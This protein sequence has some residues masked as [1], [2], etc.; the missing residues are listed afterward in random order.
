LAKVQFEYQY[1]YIPVSNI[2]PFGHLYLE[3]SL[4]YQ[5]HPPGID[6]GGLSGQGNTVKQDSKLDALLTKK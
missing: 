3:N 6:A 4:L 1:G 2:N 5:N